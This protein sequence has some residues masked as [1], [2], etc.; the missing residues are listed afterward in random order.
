[1]PRH[2]S[3]F[4]PATSRVVGNRLI[5]VP[6]VSIERRPDGYTVRGQPQ[7]SMG[8]RIPRPGGRDDGIYASWRW[9]GARLVV[10]NDR[11]G[12]YPIFYFADQRRVCVSP[13]I[14]RLLAEG[15]DTTIDDEAMAV[16]LRLGYMIGEATP[17]RH[18]RCVPP[19]AVFEW[20]TEGLKVEGR[21]AV[22]RPSSLSR[23]AALD[24]FIELFRISMQRRPLAG[25][26]VLPLSGGRDSRHIF[27]EVCRRGWKPGHC[28]SVDLRHEQDAAVAAQL[29]NSEG[30]PIRI[31]TPA[32]PS[33]K[34]ETR[35]NLETSFCS[36]EHTWSLTLADHLDR[37]GAECA[38]DGIAG[39]VLSSSRSLSA[40][41][42][43]WFESGDFRSL[44]MNLIGNDTFTRQALPAELRNRWSTERAIAQIAAELKRCS[45]APNPMAAFVFRNRTRRE[46]ALYSYGYLRNMRCVYAPFLDHDLFDHL[47]S[48]PAPMLLDRRLHDD[49][50][51]RAYPERAGIPFAAKTGRR[52]FEDRVLA[53]FAG[54]ALR[55]LA[56]AEH[57]NWVDTGYFGRRFL[58]SWL[59][60]WRK[61]DDTYLGIRCLYLLQLEDTVTNGIRFLPEAALPS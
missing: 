40:E 39:D 37:E 55:I 24:G 14:A 19:D 61:E 59:N 46:I 31:I 2:T 34:N 58:R 27:F 48:L 1:M 53:G 21:R 33:F 36:D 9:D 8:H 44:A 17:F 22:P 43:R 3:V 15:A 4:E 12:F 47:A 23:D 29:A 42:Q 13:I 7:C 57:R 45:E 54:D 6:F 16:F 51:R 60:L 50:I 26:C 20:S 56:K 10:E 11:S 49:A 25:R 28:V 18:I 52:A 5:G 35:R 38:W 32:K 41:R 30:V